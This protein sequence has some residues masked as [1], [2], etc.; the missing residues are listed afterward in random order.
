MNRHQLGTESSIQKVRQGGHNLT[1]YGGSVFIQS[2]LARDRY[3]K[4]S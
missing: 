1:V 4:D 3:W 2:D